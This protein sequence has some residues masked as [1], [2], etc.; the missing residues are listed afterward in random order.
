MTEQKEPS[1]E[2]TPQVVHLIDLLKRTKEGRIRVPKFQR[3]FVWNRQDIIDLFDSIARQYPI[4]TLFLWGANP[5]PSSRRNIGP[6]SL[7]DYKGETWLV[8]DGQQRLTTLVGVLLAGEKQWS[9]KSDDDPDQWRLF[10]DANENAFT[11]LSSQEK[12]P[13]HYVPV[14][15]LLD[16][17]QLFKHLEGML[18]HDDPVPTAQR[19]GRDVIF[20][21][22]SRAQEVARAIQTYR[23]PL[24]EIRTNSLSIA[25]ESFSRLNKKGRS[26]GQDEMFSALTYE[27][28]KAHSFHLA[29]E[30]DK[31]QSEMIRSGFGEVDRA[32]LLRA[33]LTAA[34]LDMYRTDWTRLG[35][36]VKEDVRSQLPQAVTE[37]ARGLEHARIFLRK[38]GVFN[39]RMLPYSMQLVSLSAFY[40]RCDNPT[41]DQASLLT[42]WFWSSSFAGWFGSGNPARVR[43]LVDELR[44]R[45]S[46]DTSPRKLE[47]MEIDQPALSTPLRFDM[48]S[49]RVRTM[50]CVLIFQKP[51]RPDGKEMGVE[52]AAKLLLQRGPQAMGTICASVTDPHLR[53]SPANRILD[54]APEATGQAKNWIIE[55]PSNVRD[56]VLRSHAIDPDSFRLLEDGDH[57]GFLQRRMELLSCIERNFMRAEQIT[58]PESEAPAPSPI[59]TDDAEIIG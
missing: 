53:R 26:I 19:A 54:V 43:R 33:V 59:D 4:G 52:E 56:K 47:N 11:H 13:S 2:I 49:A 48:R 28:D 55:L 35:D 40:G 39:S 50:L 30:I 58:P 37:A 7:P 45:V 20:V 21:W 46:K 3:E 27:E 34:G 38:L 36:Q 41:A 16:T 22:V 12:A 17:V 15:A 5:V 29:T 14:P 18:R 25:V 1:P 44:D 10:Y 6:L 23:I 31:L 9:S 42:R 24:V 57:D 8:L 51:L 32:I